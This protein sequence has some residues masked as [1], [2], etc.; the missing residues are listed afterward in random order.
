L[1]RYRRALSDFVRTLPI[2]LEQPVPAPAEPALKA[3]EGGLA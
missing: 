3:I 2:R 1:A